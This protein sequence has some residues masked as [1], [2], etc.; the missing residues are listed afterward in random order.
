MPQTF[1]VI[2]KGGT[3]VNHD[4]RVQRDLGITGG[5]IMALGDLSRAPRS[6]RA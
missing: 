5:K 4:G 2:L 3:V 1:D 6:R